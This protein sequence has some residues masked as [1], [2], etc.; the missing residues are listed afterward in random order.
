MKVVYVADDGVQFDDYDD[1]ME[2][3]FELFMKTTNIKVYD[4]NRHRLDNIHT[5]DSYNQSYR[6]VL[7]DEAD[8]KALQ[9]IQDYTGF[10]CDI[11][12]VGTWRYND[13]LDRWYIKE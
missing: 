8:L 2:H 11:D 9:T 13:K 1:C 6:V 5:E 3:E 12:K 7:K 10:Y 4:K